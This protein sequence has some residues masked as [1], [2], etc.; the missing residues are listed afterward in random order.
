MNE[1]PL[2]CIVPVFRGVP[3]ERTKLAKAAPHRAAFA[4]SGPGMFPVQHLERLRAEIRAAIR[5]HDMHTAWFLVGIV[6]LTPIEAASPTLAPDAGS[7]LDIHPN[8][9]ALRR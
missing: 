7:S 1:A 2:Y 8:R 9:Q 5:R 6:V 3:P 4:F